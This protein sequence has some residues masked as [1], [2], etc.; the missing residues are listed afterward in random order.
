MDLSRLILRY[1]D[2]FLKTA[3]YGGTD[4][5]GERDITTAPYKYAKLFLEEAKGIWK[6]GKYRTV[7][8]TVSIM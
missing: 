6:Q 4:I 7:L 1:I 8:S 3:E 5:I 2:V